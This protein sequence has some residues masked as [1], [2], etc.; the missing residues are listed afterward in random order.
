MSA[1]LPA[2]LEVAALI[3]QVQ[4]AGGFAAV[5]AKGE[6]DSGAILLV[7]AGPGRAPAA[8][9]RM[10]RPD[11]ERIWRITR[12]QDPENAQDFVNYLERRRAQ[13]GDLWIVELDI[14]A[15]ERFVGLPVSQN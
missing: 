6:P 12:N 7:L 15:A 9:E 10:P 14:A 8:C 1:R 2:A 11:G 13:D 5:L 3:R 4:T